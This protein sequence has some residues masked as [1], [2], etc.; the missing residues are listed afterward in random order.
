[1]EDVRELMWFS[2]KDVLPKEDSCVLIY[3]AEE[4]KYTYFYAKYIND[5]ER[6]D[7]YWTDGDYFIEDCGV[8]RWAYIPA[9]FM[10]EEEK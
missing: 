9:P 8:K 2:P 3:V 5:I 10:K 7:S 6:G 1:M 4:G